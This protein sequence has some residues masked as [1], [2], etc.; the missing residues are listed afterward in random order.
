MTDPTPDY[1]KQ[2][3]IAWNAEAASYIANGERAWQ[4]EPS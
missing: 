2:N 4:S 1:L 3:R